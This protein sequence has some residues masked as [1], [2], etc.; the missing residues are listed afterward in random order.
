MGFLGFANVYA[1][2][3][4]LSVAIVAMINST[5]VPNNSTLDVCPVPTPTNSSI[6]TVS[7][8]IYISQKYYSKW[9]LK[10]MIL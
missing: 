4:N 6:P 2:R 7:I 10:Y 3:V 9:F 5:T 1:M 8:L